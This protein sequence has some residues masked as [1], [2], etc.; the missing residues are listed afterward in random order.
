MCSV[1]LPDRALDQYVVFGRTIGTLLGKTE[2]G[3]V[4]K[5]IWD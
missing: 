1:F 3:G 5:D 2:L 4:T